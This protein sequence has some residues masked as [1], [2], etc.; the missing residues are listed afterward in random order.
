MLQIVQ[1][2]GLE[3]YV[4][5]RATSTYQAGRRS[6]SWIKCVVRHRSPMIVGG[7][8]PGGGAHGGGL[9]TLPVGAHNTDGE[10]CYFTWV[11]ECRIGCPSACCNA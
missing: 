3:G 2:L 9:G 1:D 10:L 8:I 11:L 5:K 4:L 7:F 6:P